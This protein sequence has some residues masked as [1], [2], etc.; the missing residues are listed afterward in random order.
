MSQ[1]MLHRRLI[2]RPP[3]QT[4]A[5]LATTRGGPRRLPEDLLRQASRRL[6]IMALIAAVLWVLGPVFGHLAVYVTQPEDP[7]WAQFRTIDG[8]AASCVVM[9]LALF[10]Y[11]RSGDR[12][13]AFVMDLA[14]VYLVAN[15]FALGLMIHW[16]PPSITPTDVV[17]TITWVGPVVLIFAAIVPTSPRKLLAA[18][19][20]A[21]SMDPIGMVISGASGEYQHGSLS[22]R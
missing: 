11:L 3:R 6:E 10:A 2:G 7:S 15:A 9:S 18:G 19:F 17:P 21:V 5:D 13:P 8:I 12:D 16:G 14:L 1:G 20:V 4:P 22:S